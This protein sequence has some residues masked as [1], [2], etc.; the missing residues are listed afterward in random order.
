MYTIFILDTALG[1]GYTFIQHS[2]CAEGEFVS[3]PFRDAAAGVSG[4]GKKFF[5]S[6]TCRR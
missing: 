4:E 2:K 6:G 3:D 1:T 5:R